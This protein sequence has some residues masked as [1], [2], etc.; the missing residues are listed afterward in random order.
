MVKKLQ[1]LLT[2]WCCACVLS[3]SVLP[4]CAETD[5]S[6][7]HALVIGNDAYGSVTSLDNPVNDARLIA[8]TLEALGFD[9]TLVTD[10]TQVTMKR[11]VA[12]FG[13]QLRQGGP[14]TVGL[15]FYAGHAV[16]SFGTNYLLPV[17]AS[18][19]DAADLDLV[20]VEAQS[21][22]RQMYS[23]RNR[24]NIVILD[25]CRN[26]PFTDIPEFNDNGLAEMDAP[27]G[28]FLAYA[29]APGRVALDGLTGNSPFTRSLAG[30]MGTPGMPIEQMFKKVRI[31]VLEETGGAQTPWDSTSLTSDFMFAAPEK[32]PVA[33]DRGEEQTWLAAQ[34]SADVA[35]LVTFLRAYPDSIHKA[36]A[37]H[38]LTVVLEYQ[39]GIDLSHTDREPETSEGPSPIEERLYSLAASD[40]GQTGFKYYL[41]LFPNGAF[42]DLARQEMEALRLQAG[43]AERA[44]SADEPMSQPTPEPPRDVTFVD[45]LVSDTQEV[46]GRSIA[47]LM[48]AIPLFPPREDLPDTY[49]K[50]Q[51][52]GSCHKWSEDRLCDYAGR[53]LSLNSE[54]SQ[55][56]KHPFGG[57]LKQNLRYWAAGGCQ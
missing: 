32:G 28:T 47:M 30:Y 35:E 20:A 2:V 41:Q 44:I 16:Q 27:T 38:L 18:L 25:A 52:C 17:D 45:P 14:E 15:F 56:L 21:V 33:L 36:E 6:E 22:L 12:Q 7:R 55:R 24:T 39:L 26:N 13:R 53:Q 31:E 4:A 34:A 40:G 48:N 11:A 49:W 9:V 10:A 46:N 23:A 29:T 19:L 51:A 43:A 8:R 42:A 5:I 3:G 1:A 50:G 54:Y 57:A 37:Q